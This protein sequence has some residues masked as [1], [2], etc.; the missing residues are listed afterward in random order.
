MAGDERGRDEL[1]RGLTLAR[2]AGLAEHVTRA[3]TNLS[4]YAV[5]ARDLARAEA[6]LADGIMYT[7][8][9]D[10]NALRLYMLAWRGYLRLLQGDWTAAAADAATVLS[11]PNV[12]AI[13]RITALVTRG[14][15]RAR[16]GDPDATGPL[17]EAL[18][19]ATAAW[20][21]RRD[22]FTADALAWT[23]FQLG[24]LAEAQTFIREAL[25]TGS[26]DRVI[27][28]HA[29]AIAAAGGRRDDA[30]QLVAGALEDHPRFDLIAAPAASA[31]RNSLT[32]GGAE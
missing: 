32:L 16:R 7:T 31:L 26:R 14:L 3:L 10:L 22:I 11:P 23:H 29:A 5:H 18:A 15:V 1:E 17:D 4:W 9:H 28:Y 12:A 8:D 25:R 6:Y 20:A 30:R 2:D 19:L 21:E 24:H 13:S 27:R